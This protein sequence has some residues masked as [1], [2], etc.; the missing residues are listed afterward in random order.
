MGK[1]PLLRRILFL[2]EGKIGNQKIKNFMLI[3]IC[4]HVLVTRCSQKKVR[5][6]KQ[7]NLGLSQNFGL[8]TFFI[9]NYY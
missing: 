8:Q 6:K 2:E 7:S 4:K 1:M 3:K 9:I 5:V